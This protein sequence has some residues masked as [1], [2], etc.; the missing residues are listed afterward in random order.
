MK[1]AIL[2]L[3]K[4]WIVA[5]RIGSGGFGEVYAASSGD[6]NAVVKFIPKTP[7][8]DRELLFA[9]ISN[10]RNV[11][12]I[13]DSGEYNERWV[14][15]M[16]R[17][18][19]SLRQYL[20][21][22]DGPLGLQEIMD[23]LTDIGDALMD[24]D[25]RVVHRDIKPENTLRLDGRWCLADFGISRYAEAS[26]A[27]DTLKY[28][29]TAAY[30]A[31]ERWRNERA[32]IAADMYALGIMAHE[33]IGGKHPFTF[34]SVDDLREQHLHVDAPTLDGVSRGLAA[35]ID[36]CLYKAPEARPSPANFRARL[37]RQRAELQKSPGL[38]QLE[39]ANHA[40]VQRR[41]IKARKES[42]GQTEAQRRATLAASS[43]TGL[44]RIS[45]QVV[46]AIGEAAP[47]A[48]VS[49]DQKDGWELRLG[50]ATLKM[51]GPSQASSFRWGGWDPQA[52]DVVCAA[53]MELRIPAN[54]RGYEGRSHSLWFGDIQESGRY[55]WF[56]TAFMV[57]PLVRNL[58]RSSR[59]PYALNPGV[60]AAK[61]VWG[62]M[63]EIQLAWPFIRLDP[64]NLDEFIDR[65]AEW[66]ALAATGHLTYPSTM[67]ERP[68]AG[69]WRRT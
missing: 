27:P 26:T 8:S 61:A 39:I 36:E 16:P 12:P 38:A 57:S 46:E 37:D 62:G 40:E 51:S 17:A 35:L 69:T 65:W 49:R 4:T 14:L 28:A 18:E 54:Y 50:P 42:E 13:I 55:G 22:T 53:S 64:D 67:P 43:R 59:E 32:T 24:L 23:V 6:A 45:A 63:A 56:E 19:L 7:G 48:V 3:D 34:G 20:E 11:V 21:R 25:G 2:A 66:L 60:D 10:A 31:P 30:A 68:T 1:G 9:D 29:M 5:D 58:S 47:A 41:A 33:L 15:V 52:F 44:A